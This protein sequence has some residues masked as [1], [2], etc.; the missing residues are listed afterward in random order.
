MEWDGKKV[1]EVW[2]GWAGTG[3]SVVEQSVMG[4]D[5]MERTEVEQHRM[6]WGQLGQNAV[7]QAG[8]P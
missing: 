8:M 1:G 5:A 6:G 3:Q 4:W 7:I 2:T